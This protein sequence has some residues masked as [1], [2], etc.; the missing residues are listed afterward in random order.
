MTAVAVT[1]PQD[2]EETIYSCKWG[3]V[4]ILNRQNYSTFAATCQYTLIVADAWG[5]VMGTEQAPA[6]INTPEGKDWKIRRNRAIQ[7][8]Y[9]SVSKSIRPTL[10]DLMDKQDTKALWEHLKAKYSNKDNK[11]LINNV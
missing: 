7:I 4:T 9:N 5:I 6:D 2:T 3:N 8:I 1:K 11:I 10:T